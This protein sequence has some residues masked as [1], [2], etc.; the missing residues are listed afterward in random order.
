MAQSDVFECHQKTNSVWDLGEQDS[1]RVF[2]KDFY[3]GFPLWPEQ[4]LVVAD[5]HVLGTYKRT[6]AGSEWKF[7]PMDWAVD[8]RWSRPAV[9]VLRGFIDPFYAKLFYAFDCHEFIRKDGGMHYETEET[10]VFAERFERLKSMVEQL[11]GVVLA[12]EIDVLPFDEYKP[13]FLNGLRAISKV[14]PYAPYGT[15]SEFE[16]ARDAEVD[17]FITSVDPTPSGEVRIRVGMYN[18]YGSVENVAVVDDDSYLACGNPE[19]GDCGSVM[20]CDYDPRLGRFRHCSDF[21][22]DECCSQEACRKSNYPWLFC[23]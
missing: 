3:T 13:L 8:R 16:V 20:A 21:A 9:V 17:V 12:P 10:T 23:D 15:H 4:R 7:V 22:Y 19:V 1:D 6:W 18:D 5:G 2:N 11:P 14:H